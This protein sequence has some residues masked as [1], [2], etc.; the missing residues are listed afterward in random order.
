MDENTLHAL[1]GDDDDDAL[2]PPPIYVGPTPHNS[3]TI[4]SPRANRVD[5]ESQSLL[6]AVHKSQ[7]P[8]NT[9][10]IVAPPSHFPPVPLNE[11]YVE[12]HEGGLIASA[13]EIINT[14]RDLF[15]VITGSSWHTGRS[16][17]ESS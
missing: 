14:A 13:V 5:K 15:G 9:G 2:R 4:M 16:W 8:Q 11:D 12:E 3:P 17:Y 10:A 6:K 7:R 1:D